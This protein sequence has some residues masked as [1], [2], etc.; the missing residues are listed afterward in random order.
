MVTPQASRPKIYDPNA[1]PELAEMRRGPRPWLVPLLGVIFVAL[2]AVSIGLTASSPN[3]DAS[4]ASVIRYYTDN[5]GRL[6]SAAIMTA[7]SIPAGLFFFALLR[8]YLRRSERARPYATI[9]LVGAIV[10]ASG[11]AL[12]AGLQLA[13]ADVPDRLTPGAAQ[14]LNIMN[15][16]LTAG[17]LIGGLATMQLGYGV[18]ILLGKAFPTWLGWLTI[19]I[20]IV[21]LL[22]PLAFIGLLATGV[23]VL[24][25][26][27]MIYP[28]LRDESPA[29]TS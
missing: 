14:A 23:W 11:G 2:V 18:A 21:S 16:D 12:T 24:I 19:A 1:H 20:G 15:N 26:S 17:L 3:S 28:K 13:L 7:V 22:G 27:A 5:K 6:Q 10:F 29:P 8:D 25:V 4:A 9:A